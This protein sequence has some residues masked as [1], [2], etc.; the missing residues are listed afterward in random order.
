MNDLT[1]LKICPGGCKVDQIGTRGKIHAF[2]FV[3]ITG[4]VG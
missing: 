1:T 2:V 3:C 4:W